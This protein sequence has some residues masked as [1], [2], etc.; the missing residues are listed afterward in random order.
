MLPAGGKTTL[1]PKITSG[2]A[3]VTL[4]SAVFDSFEGADACGGTLTLSEPVITPTQ[5]GAITVNAGST[6]GFCHF[7]ATG[8]DGTVTQSEDGWIVVGNPPAGMA[9]S[10]GNGQTAG[11]GTT[12]S[13][14][15]AVTLTPGQSGGAASGASILFTANAGTLSNGTASGAKVIAVTNSA[16]VASVTLTLP[17][18]PQTVTI[19]AEAPYAL[20]NATATLTETAQ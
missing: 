5:P 19:Q 15:L 1:H 7:T 18:T 16:G 9:V 14:P 2:P 3:N 11:A 20:G 12:L 6:P 8:S 13:T 10:G 17:N 4:L